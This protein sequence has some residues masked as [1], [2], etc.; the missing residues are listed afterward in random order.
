[1]KTPTCI[2]GCLLMIGGCGL[3]LG[4]Q[5]S[6]PE[7]CNAFGRAA[8]D[9]PFPF[10]QVTDAHW[11]TQQT[12]AEASD[13]V[14]YDHEFVGDT[15]KLTPLGEKHV[16]QVALRLCHVPFP[17]VVEQGTNNKNPKLDAERRQAVIGKLAQLGLCNID[18]RVVVA[19]AIA[20][21][22]S[23]QEGESAYYS[24]IISSGGYGGNG[25]G[26]GYSGG[27]VGGVGGGGFGG[28][29]VGGGIF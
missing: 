28:G 26:Y 20:E 24:T 11:E 1:M 23:A 8:Y 13:F 15:S 22:I 9:R 16:Q 4:C 7:G 18:A 3:M 19:P 2:Y 10:G 27:F 21:G 5:S 14:L 12:N 25:G 17:V 6:Q 29:G